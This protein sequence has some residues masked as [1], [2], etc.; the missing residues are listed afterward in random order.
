ML[1]ILGIAASINTMVWTYGVFVAMMS[2][3]IVYLL[4]MGYA[5]DLVVASTDA[6]AMIAKG[7][8]K[9][10]FLIFFGSTAASAAYLAVDFTKWY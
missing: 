9:R 1:A 3:N 2:V 7:Q 4:I 5:Y 6:N 10:D 8:M